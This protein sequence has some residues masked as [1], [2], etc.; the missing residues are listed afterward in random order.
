MVP[1]KAILL[2]CRFYFSYSRPSDI[3]NSFYTVIVSILL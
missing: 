1:C 2:T 3:V